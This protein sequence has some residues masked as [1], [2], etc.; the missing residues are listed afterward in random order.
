[1][2]PLIPILLIQFLF[3][4][5]P[6]QPTGLLLD[7]PAYP[8][9]PRQSLSD[10]GSKDL[11][12]KADLKPYCPEVR[13]QGEAYSCVGW[14]AGYAA[15]TIQRAIRHG[16]TDAR[17]ITHNANSALFLYNQIKRGDCRQGSRISDAMQF[18]KTNGDCL[19]RHFDFDV[20]DCRKSPVPELAQAARSFAIADFL[21]LF[22][23]EDSAHVKVRRVK[24]ALAQGK[25]VVVGVAVR[26]NFFQ[27]QN[28]AYWL[29]DTGDTTFAG[30]HAM[31][32]VGYDDAKNAFQLMNSWGREW[33]EQGFIRIKY[34][35]FG[36]FCKYAYVL[37]LT[38]S[39]KTAFTL[40]ELPPSPAVESRPLREL[41]GGF[42]FRH[43]AGW[44]L[45]GDPRWETAAAEWTGTHYVLTKKDWRTEQDQFRFLTK[46]SAKGEYLYLFSVDAA[47]DTMTHFP[48][49]KEGWRESALLLSGQAEIAV[50]TDPSKALTLT[51]PGKDHLVALFSKR[52]LEDL[53]A[54]IGVLK[55][56]KADLPQALREALGERVVPDADVSFEKNEVRFQASTR[57][58][59]DVVAL[60]LEVHSINE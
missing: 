7:D 55:T 39:E 51:V 41:A 8:T 50:P 56:R 46:A 16:C 35:V 18:L 53:P 31:V 34:D 57:S 24:Q 13:H 52:P 43:L 12:P 38:E 49:Q 15:L 29:A 54:L 59:G 32:V 27:L 28:A 44:L 33:G 40:D 17:T 19:A 45:N 60:V 30:G 26:R 6:A 22:G 21:T 25:P 14:A 5:A 36:R 4:C 37:H 42:E 58:K 11:P 20:N 10:G 3:T 9:L 48:K 23:S 47:G 1:M 2:R